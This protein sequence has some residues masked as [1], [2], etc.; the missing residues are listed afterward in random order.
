MPLVQV[1]LRRSA[2]ILLVL[3]AGI[4][5]SRAQTTFQ[6]TYGG[7]SGDEG[8]S[9]Q[10]T[11]DGGYIIAGR[12]Y[13]VGAGSFDMYLIKT[14]SSGDTL[15]TRTYGGTSGEEGFS[16]Q[17]TTDGGY[18]VAGITDSLGSGRDVYLIKTD[19]SGDTLWTRT[20]GGTNGE[21]CYSVQ[22]TSDGGYIVAGYTES[23]GANG[24]VYLV[25]TN[26]TGDTLWTRTYGGTAPDYGTS[27]QQTT[28]GGY[29]FTGDTHSFGAGGDVYLVKTNSSGDTL[30]TRTYGGTAYEWGNSVRQTSDGGYIV[31][32]YT[33]SFGAGLGDAYLIKTNSSGDTLWTRTYGGTNREAGYSVQQTSDGGYIV[34][35]YTESFGSGSLDAYLIKTNSSGDTLWTRTY[36]G[37]S[38]EVGYSVQQTSDGGYIVAGN[39]Y[40]FGAGSFDVYLIKTLGDGTVSVRDDRS[41]MPTGFVLLQNYPNPFNP[42]TVIRYQIPVRSRVSV[43]V[44]DVLG[45]NVA[46]LVDEVQEVGYKSIEWDARGIASGVYFYRLQAG[47][48]T[49]SKKL[50]LLR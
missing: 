50:I 25:K 47:A 23:F 14:N 43:N 29:I 37:T 45:R 2:L 20:Y 11:S 46:T 32:G 35:G 10:Q 48:F 33:S 5:L 22:Q 40:S 9:V 19:S 21:D 26:S 6:R 36:G 49:E 31:A 13:S 34:A 27:V 3:C 4:S 15:W 30:W 38:V 17:Q 1:S 28:D 8:F 42:A 41:G 44:Y 12:T 24:D 16:V 39:T 18:I 7:T